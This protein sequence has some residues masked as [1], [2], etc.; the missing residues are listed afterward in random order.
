[1]KNGPQER[2]ARKR[3]SRQKEMKDKWEYALCLGSG[4]E[5]KRMSEKREGGSRGGKISH[6]LIS[7]QQAEGKKGARSRFSLIAIEENQ[8]DEREGGWWCA[9]WEATNHGGVEGRPPAKTGKEVRKICRGEKTAG[10]E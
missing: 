8:E 10:G 5:L 3:G 7:V 2:R 9:S 4:E 1:M 6:L